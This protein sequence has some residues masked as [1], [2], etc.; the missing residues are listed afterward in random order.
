MS[1]KAFRRVLLALSIIDVTNSRIVLAIKA[2]E[3]GLPEYRN[4][5]RVSISFLFFGER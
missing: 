3:R 5:V 4:D 2:R 1:V